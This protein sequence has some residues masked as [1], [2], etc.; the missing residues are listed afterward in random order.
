MVTAN[1]SRLV[2]A[3]ITAVA[4][5]GCTR[6]LYEASFA[7]AM[8]VAGWDGVKNLTHDGGV[9]FGGQPTA[10]AFRTAQQRGIKVVVNLRSDQEMMALDFDEPALVRALGMEYVAIPIT[11]DTF[12]T[13]DADRLKDELGKTQGPVLIHCASSN[14]VGALWAMYL[15]RHR[16]VAENDAIELGRRA[17]LRSEALIETIKQVE[18]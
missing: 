8:A 12:S 2:L 18:D 14:R 7:P 15:R 16:G 13:E 4:L 6:S 9:Y 3:A 1:R 10:D 17:G 11:P 5:P